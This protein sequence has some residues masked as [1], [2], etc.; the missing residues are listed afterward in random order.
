MF[1]FLNMILDLLNQLLNGI[2]GL[3]PILGGTVSQGVL[4]GIMVLGVYIT[5]R[6]LNIA[7]LTVDGSFAMGGCVCAV[8][9]VKYQVDPVIALVLAT[10]AGFMAGAITGI[11]HTVFEIPAILAGILTQIALWSINLRIM[12]GKSNIPLLK[13]KTVISGLADGA[14]ITQS[15][16]SLAVG[17]LVAVLM[18]VVLYWF[19]GTEIGSALRATGNNED[20]IRAL[21]VNTKVTKL[22]ALMISNGLVGLSGGLI[23]QSQKYADIGMGTGAIVIGLASIVIGEVLGGRLRSFASKLAAAVVGAVI[24]FLIRAIVLQI[25]LSANDMKLFSAVL[26]ALALSIPVMMTKW[27]NKK[28][29]SEEGEKESC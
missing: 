21:G 16:A 22:L 11:L 29:Y 15:Q 23:C 12:G 10:V 13:V 9:V 26:V 20:M 8:L 1:F 18:V 17:I 25:G 3:L 27:R 5:F 4:W 19:F 7:D 28:S 6:L 2:A 14:G 24:Y